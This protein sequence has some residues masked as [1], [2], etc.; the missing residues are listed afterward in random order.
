MKLTLENLE[1]AFRKVTA[2]PVPHQ[3][4][5]ANYPGITRAATD[6]GVSRIHLW[7]VLTG[8]RES[9]PLMARWHA[10][11]AKHPE[12]ARLQHR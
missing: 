4:L 11:L 9:K 5:K 10:W 3:S 6:L 12:S 1:R 7:K 8:E 2:P